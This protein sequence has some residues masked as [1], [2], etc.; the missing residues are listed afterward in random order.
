MKKRRNFWKK[1]CVTSSYMTCLYLSTTF[2]LNAYP[3][4]TICARHVT[5]TF[6]FFHLKERKS[7]FFFMWWLVTAPSPRFTW[8]W[9]SCNLTSYWR[10]R[11]IKVHITHTPNVKRLFS[12]TLFLFSPAHVSCPK[13]PLSLSLSLSSLESIILFIGWVRWR[14]AEKSFD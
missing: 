9:P 10:K 1:C 13:S 4:V 7:S 6:F 2:R 8:W 12:L 3:H 5:C 11:M 14:G